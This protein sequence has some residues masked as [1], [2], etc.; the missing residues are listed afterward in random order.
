MPSYRL[1]LTAISLIC[2]LVVGT[3]PATVRAIAEGEQDA[4]RSTTA[5]ALFPSDG[6][7]NTNFSDNAEFISGVCAQIERSARQADLP[8]GFLAKLIWKESR[9]DPDAISPA[10]AEGIAQFMP[11]TAA[12]W[13]L[14]N[15]FEP[16][17]AIAASAR[18]LGYLAK[19]Y[20]NL[21][22]AAAAYNAGEARV[23]AWRAGRS[24]LP[25]ET[26]DYVYSI[27]GH[28]AKSWK[29]DAG[30]EVNYR[31]D[32]TLEFQTACEEFRL[33]K[34]P[35]Q[36]RFANTYF[37]RALSLAQNGDHK[38]A[39]LR[40]SIAIRLKPDFA[41]AYNNRGLVYRK[42][43]Q[44]ED[45]IENYSV[46]IRK[47]PDYANAYNNRGFANRKLKRY[48]AA[49]A[50]YSRAIELNPAH[51]TAWF[52]RGFSKAKLGLF[53]EALEDYNQSIRLKSGSPLVLYNRALAYKALGRSE[54]AKGDLDIAIA[55]HGAYAKAYFQR[56]A[57]M[58]DLGKPEQAKSD[59]QKSVA[60]N[61]KFGHE[62][63]RVLFE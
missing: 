14:E 61:T 34:A 27:T 2:V 37:N 44:F 58:L 32:E 45:A 12:N 48:Q 35:L 42:L 39:L 49:I 7:G 53:D 24:G 62:K 29:T 15:A 23:D 8:A 51:A 47:A 31:L 59:Y 52:N 13:G 55:A 43:G 25:G 46:A 21:G 11:Y 5:T 20:G 57:L 1:C 36:R 22:L 41:H 40:Y 63:Y 9:F 16:L 6:Q 26:R 60:L 30:P 50:D 4:I 38:G 10:G 56:A 17:E 19:G 18:L 33:I 54:Q 28:A 3:F